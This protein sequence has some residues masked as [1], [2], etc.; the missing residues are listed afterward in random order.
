MR[1]LIYDVE[2]FANDNQTSRQEIVREI[3]NLVDI[4]FEDN[5]GFTQTR[6]QEL[7]YIKENVSRIFMEFKAYYDVEQQKIYRY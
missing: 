3:A 6:K 2:I 4:A 5:L 1:Y 7:P